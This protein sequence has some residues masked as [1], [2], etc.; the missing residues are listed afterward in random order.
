MADTN[1]PLGQRGY[2]GWKMTF[3]GLRSELEKLFKRRFPDILF[4]TDDQQG[5]G[6]SG[7]GFATAQEAEAACKARDSESFTI[8]ELPDGT[9]VG[10]MSCE[11]DMPRPPAPEGAPTCRVCGCWEYAACWDDE[12]GACWWVE[13]DLCSH[14]KEKETDDG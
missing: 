14:C 12:R 13:P 9:F 3:T 8:Y 4:P 2:V 11:E 5:K 10:L 7:G 6:M 1:D